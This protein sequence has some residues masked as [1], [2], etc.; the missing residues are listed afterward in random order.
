ME[1]K[2]TVLIVTDGAEST[3]KVAGEI[4]AVFTAASPGNKVKVV[5]AEDFTATDLLPAD[6][7]FFGAEKPSPASFAG[8]EQ[9][10]LH[11]N[12]AGRPG[13]LFAGSAKAAAYLRRIVHDCELRVS[14]GPFVSGSSGSVKTW[15]KTVK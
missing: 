10:L 8:L 11:I 2:K 5:K 6:L 9:L 14:A 13:G 12:L 1:T 4:A 15:I 7:C 3:V